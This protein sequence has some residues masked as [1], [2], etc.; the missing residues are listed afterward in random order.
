MKRMNGVHM[1]HKNEQ[2]SPLS[3]L[4]LSAF[5]CNLALPTLTVLWTKGTS[6]FDNGAFFFW[7][8]ERE[9]Q[10]LYPSFSRFRAHAHTVPAP[11]PP[12]PPSL[13]R[14][15][16]PCLSYSPAIRHS[17]NI[18][19]LT[20]SWG[21]AEKPS[22]LKAIVTL[23]PNNKSK[24]N[25]HACRNTLSLSLSQTHTLQENTLLFIYF[26]T[27]A[28]SLIAYIINTLFSTSSKGQI[29]VPSNSNVESKHILS[30]SDD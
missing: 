6:L 3:F 8:N 9:L 29:E 12:R 27:K 20:G 15:L 24:C 26:S 16:S 7:M 1:S 25:M 30:N 18:I 22:C 4:A 28:N 5:L 19:A 21:L 23:Y 10:I 13:A 11:P 14:S 17:N 2:R